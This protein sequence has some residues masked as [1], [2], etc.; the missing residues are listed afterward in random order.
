MIAFHQSSFHWRAWPNQPDPIYKYAGGFVGKPGQVY[1]VRFHLQAACTVEDKKTGHKTDMYLGAP[2]R[3]EYTIARR[4]LFQLPSDEFRMAFSKEMIIPIS[5]KPSTETSDVYLSP[6][7]T[8][9]QFHEIDIR[10]YRSVE[11]LTDARQLVNATLN[12]DLMNGKT[13]YFDPG[14]SLQVS[15]EYPVDLI[16]INQEQSEFQI[17]TGPVIIP[18]LK[19]W[20]GS[21]VHR[22][23]LADI[24][25][26]DFDYAE[27]ILRREIE[28]AEREKQWY[29]KPRGRD[30]LCLN[31]P[32][33]PP[34]GYP[35]QR[36][37]PLVYNETWE[38][39]AENIILKT[40]NI[41]WREDRANQL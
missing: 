29:E 27:F 17:C 7:A 21:E 28:P 41:E 39:E 12:R 36:P 14:Q 20:D 23:F 9:F 13:T 30:R 4:N 6:L 31:N 11:P 1:Q 8:Q 33:N 18:D 2:C 3:T 16:N 35:P 15:L 22:V 26:S 32:E 37:K 38:K 34:L 25:I 40:Q 10:Q 24:A 19:T 5:R